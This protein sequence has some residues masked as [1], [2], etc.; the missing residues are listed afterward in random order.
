MGFLVYFWALASNKKSF[1]YFFLKTSALEEFLMVS[2]KRLFLIFQEMELSS[3]KIR[4]NFLFFSKKKKKLFL[5]FGNN[6]LYFLR[7]NFW[8]IRNKK[9]YSKKT[10]DIS[11]NGT[12]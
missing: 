9:T 2:E 11:R 10:S 6:F 8:S 12:F 4:K 7:E 5:Y 3:L 1:L